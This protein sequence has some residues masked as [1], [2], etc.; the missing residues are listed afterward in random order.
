MTSYG[1]MSYAFSVLVTRSAAG[2]DLGVGA[3]AVGF[4]AGVLVSGVAAVFAGAIADVHGTRGLMAGGSVLGAIGLALFA[5]SQEPW[6]AILVMAVVLGP[7]MA[8]TFYEPVY[9][10]MNRWFEPAERPRAYGVLTF[11]SGLSITIYTPLTRYLVSS[12]GWR[13]AVLVLAACLLV[14]GTA[15]PAI[16]REPPGRGGSGWAPREFIADIQDGFRHGNRQFWAFTLAFF[17]ATTAFSGFAFHS[18]A[19]LE[20]R[21]FDEDAVASAIAITGILSLPA[22]LLL[23]ALSA[24]FPAPAMLAFCLG[25]L[26][27]AAWIPTIAGDWWQV[28]LYVGMFGVV[29]GSVYPLRA[30]VTAEGFSGPYFGRLIGV[31]ALFVAL[32]RA[33]GPAIVAAAGTDALGYERSFRV[34]AVVLVLAAFWSWL[35]MR[36]RPPKAPA[37]VQPSD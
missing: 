1:T 31:Q 32:A 23:P 13:E 36:R 18:I 34:I 21:G 7:A 6:Q 17:V 37:Q 2:G 14:I 30:L 33:L 25:T 27:F 22:R 24:R 3:V 10:L 12:I 8:A 29:F 20:G 16:I 28:W 9:V 19:Q 26:G 35:V 5:A 11:L 15:V 4:S